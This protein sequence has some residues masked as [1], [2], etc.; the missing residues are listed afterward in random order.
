MPESKK[1]TCK[2][3][4]LKGR[5]ALESYIIQKSAMFPGEWVVK[6]RGGTASKAGGHVAHAPTLAEAKKIVAHRLGCKLPARRK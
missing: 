6:H 4:R 5:Y 3:T 2:F 1:K